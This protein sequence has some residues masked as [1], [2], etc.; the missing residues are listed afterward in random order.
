MQSFS[1]EQ[2]HLL[3]DI[4]KFRLNGRQTQQTPEIQKLATGIHGNPLE[5]SHQI[6]GL[7]KPLQNK[8][9]DKNVFRKRTASQII[10]DGYITG[11]T[12]ADLVFV[13]LARA[14]GLPTIYVET[15]DENWLRS[16]GSS[17]EGHQ[18]AEVYDETSNRWFWVDPMAGR[19]DI[20]APSSEKRVIFGRGF[21]SWD[22]GLTDFDS[23]SQSFNEFRKQWL[24]KQGS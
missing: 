16:G 22:M 2:S 1:S 13:T 6:L 7:M 10:K 19:V 3:N 9:F 23:L 11:C 12:D 8:P 20:S 21:D 18:Y 5:R 24:Q 4:V 15:I 14:S 17:I